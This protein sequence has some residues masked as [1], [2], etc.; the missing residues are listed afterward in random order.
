M[1][2]LSIKNAGLLCFALGLGLFIYGVVVK[3][4]GSI[5][6]GN[7]GVCIG[8]Y[9]YVRLRSHERRARQ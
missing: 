6:V 1:K 5:I 7:L 9:G 8:A 3:D 4:I 2:K